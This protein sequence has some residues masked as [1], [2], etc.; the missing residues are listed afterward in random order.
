LSLLFFSALFFP[1]DS[2]LPT[3]SPLRSSPAP[4]RGSVAVNHC[5]SVNILVRVTHCSPEGLQ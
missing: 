2:R 3:T 5:G 1:V 4:P